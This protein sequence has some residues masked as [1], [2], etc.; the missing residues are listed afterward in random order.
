MN[1]NFNYTA[2]SV[3]NQGSMGLIYGLLGYSSGG[4][5]KFLAHPASPGNALGELEANPQLN[6]YRWYPNRQNPSFRV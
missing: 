5:P 1:L 3:E 2:L 4:T 6:C